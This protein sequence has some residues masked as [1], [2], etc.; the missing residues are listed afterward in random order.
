MTLMIHNPSSDKHNAS[1]QNKAV[2]SRA[3]TAPLISVITVVRNG[4]KTLEQTI[5][6]VLGQSYDGIEY[7]IIDG[8]STDGS[9]DIIRKFDDRISYW[10]SEPDNSIYDAMNKGIAVSTGD[11]IGL[12]NSDD[13]YEEHAIQTVV[14]AYIGS[15]NKENVIIFGNFYVLDEVSDIKTEHISSMQFWKGMTISHQTMFVSRDIYFGRYTYNLAYKYAADYDFFVRSALNKVHFVHT[16][17][18]LV[19]FRNTGAT[20]RKVLPIY[21]ETLLIGRNYL[22]TFSIRYV[23]L[24]LRVVRVLLQ[25]MVKRVIN[26]FFGQ[27]AFKVTKI[28]QNWL[29][30]RTW[31]DV[32]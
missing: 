31:H 32:P 11:L 21:R 13:Y 20:Y 24:I 29:Q 28:I 4:A 2:S 3:A 9:L 17:R 19:N 6:S 18:F 14:D 25:T 30:D 27:K 10:I 5:K 8:G 1:S 15:G 12:L 16:G 7:I 26:R 22:G 23:R